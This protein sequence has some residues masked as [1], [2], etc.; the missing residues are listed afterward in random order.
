MAV[1]LEER[2]RRLEIPRGTR[3][4]DWAE[5]VKK[6]DKVRLR[7]D[8]KVEKRLVE[9][10]RKMHKNEQRVV[11]AKKN[12]YPPRTTLAPRNMNSK[13]L[14][15]LTP[16]KRNIILN[17]QGCFKCRQLY[18]DHVGANC[19]NDFPPAESYKPL[20]VE[21]AEAV[22]DS[23]NKPKTQGSTG[24]GAAGPLHPGPSRP[25]AH[26]G[27]TKEETEDTWSAVLGVGE[28]D[29]DEN[30]RCVRTRADPPF[31]SGHLAWRC[32]IDGPAVS[33][34]LTVTTLIDNSFHLVLIDERLV[35]ELRLRR[36]KLPVP[37]KARLAMGEEE[38]V[39]SEWERKKLCSQNGLDSKP[40][41]RT[42]NG[43][44]GQLGP[45]SPLN[46][47]IL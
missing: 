30:D 20:T 19:P 11:E 18:I 46:F 33:E 23:K 28:E 42:S 36:R 39:F 9:M 17:H 3:F 25:V 2:V 32:R 31:S 27:Y 26:I 29:S 22:H 7:D 14:P 41:P 35:M 8:E 4:K 13:P 21:H 16:S 40:F 44:H 10:A 24:P 38:V 1:D 37:R 5:K 45:L 47:H 12:T 43:H 15:K 6:E 34:P